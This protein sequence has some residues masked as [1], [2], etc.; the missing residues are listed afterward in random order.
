MERQLRI[1]TESCSR[2]SRE[3]ACY[4]REAAEQEAQ[5]ER[6]SGTYESRQLRQALEETR[7]MIPVCRESLQRHRQALEAFVCGHRDSGLD[8]SAALE[9]LRALP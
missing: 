5:L 7:A 3:I 8:L 6:S 2:V 9:A 4:Q 1:L